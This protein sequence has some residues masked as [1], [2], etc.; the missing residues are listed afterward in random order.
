MTTGSGSRDG[1]AGRSD[2]DD[3][4]AGGAGDRAD[5]PDLRAM[6]AVWL[7]MRDEA[8]PDGGLAELLAAARAKAETMQTRPAFWQRLVA[9]L[10]RPPA[11]ALATVMVL[12][13]G[14]VLLTRHPM[15]AQR[16]ASRATDLEIGSGLGA[17]PAANE[18]PAPVAPG[19]SPVA[20]GGSPV[21]PGSSPVAVGGAPVTLG[22]AG[23][24]SRGSGAGLDDSA[25]LRAP[26]AGSTEATAM[27]GGGAPD[28]ARTLEEAASAPSSGVA[29]HEEDRQGARGT[30]GTRGADAAGPGAA[31]SL[32]RGTARPGLGPEDTDS[33]DVGTASGR[34]SATAGSR[35]GSVASGQRSAAADKEEAPA[36]PP[37]PRSRQPAE[38]IVVPSEASKLQRRGDAPGMQRG[39]FAS[40][41][42]VKRT[43]RGAPAP[44]PA[45]ALDDQAEGAATLDEAARSEADEAKPRDVRTTERAAPPANI[46]RPGSRGGSLAQLYLQCESA[47]RRGD[48]SAVKRIVERITTSDRRYRARLAKDSPIAKCLTD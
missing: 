12:V 23:A 3:G 26:A 13:C 9:G 11:M 16:E 2:G 40:G 27:L 44:E 42:D 18:A 41:P 20:P 35:A 19:G 33:M 29:P 6:R 47:A 28:P 14:A 15:E 32:H 46:T 48:C 24:G 39:A 37:S 38:P 17:P 8:P 34:G 45:R 43:Q 30:R 7:S 25:K 5:H 36:R 4:A 1:G 21:A 22:A 10:R 31:A